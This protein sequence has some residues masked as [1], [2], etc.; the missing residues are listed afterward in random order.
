MEQSARSGGS[1]AATH[2]DWRTR[3]RTLDYRRSYAG[4]GA[5]VPPL[6]FAVLGVG[7]G[8]AL[9]FGVLRTSL[10]RPAL[11][12]VLPIGPELVDLLTIAVPLA[13]GALI[14]VVYVGRFAAG[15][16]RLRIPWA[17]WERLDAAARARGLAYEPWG[18]VASGGFHPGGQRLEYRDVLRRPDGVVL[19]ERH[20][21]HEQVLNR[22]DDSDSGRRVRYVRNIERHGY[23]KVP[24]GRTY[25]QLA[26]D[27]GWGGRIADG[28]YLR[29][30]P[31]DPSARLYAEFP[32][33][34][35][36]HGLFTAEL[37]AVLRSVG[38]RISVTTWNET[39][40][41]MIFEVIDPDDT[42]RQDALWR[43][44]DILIAN[45][46]AGD[47]PLIPDE[48]AAVPTDRVGNPLPQ[49]AVRAREMFGFMG[50]QLAYGADRAGVPVPAGLLPG[51]ESADRPKR[52]E[53]IM[54]G[55]DG[56]G[57]SSAS[58]AETGRRL[59]RLLLR[60]VLLLAA[61]LLIAY[62]AR[63]LLT[64]EWTPPLG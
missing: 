41:V 16:A 58:P 63:G 17:R 48:A 28:S 2:H 22:Y 33:V 60:L 23:L 49:E 35:E 40:R 46:A 20:L 39:A 11:E 26:L 14:L 29:E 61:A 44:A 15:A 57:A 42:A 7:L 30:L 47:A 18:E 45:A 6:V 25:S 52:G 1:F 8:G 13:V 32:F 43:A 38:S 64:G 54:G 9:W 37:I 36:A 5:I 50:R 31:A 24:L 59:G 53:G 27:L 34:D 51:G 56:G 62:L 55:A 12:Q 21:T 19:A 3:A 10:V 4:W